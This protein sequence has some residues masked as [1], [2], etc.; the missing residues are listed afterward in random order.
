MFFLGGGG[1]NDK[2]YAYTMVTKNSKFFTSKNEKSFATH[3]LPLLQIYLPM[4]NTTHQS[5]CYVSLLKI[6]Q[7]HNTK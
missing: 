6:F 4:K 7:I 3:L 5:K 2:H 1:V